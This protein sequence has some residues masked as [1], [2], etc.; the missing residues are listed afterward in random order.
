MF[1][2]AFEAAL[3]ELG[4]AGRRALEQAHLALVAGGLPCGAALVDA[5]GAAVAVGRNCAYDSAADVAVL[6]GTP[7][8]HAELNVLAAVPT[9]R[10]LTADTLWSTQ[11]PCAMCTAAIDFCGV[12]TTRYLAADPAFLG[13]D[14]P[15]A[16]IVA[17]PTIADPTLGPWAAV[18]NAMFLH[19]SLRSGGPAGER[20]RRNRAVEPE[21]TDLA[22]DLYAEGVFTRDGVPF[23]DLA[24]DLWP[25][26]VE[27]AARRHDRLAAMR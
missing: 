11:Q 24:A 26:L 19:P 15:R 18:G 17:D 2:A 21:C 8:A 22:V 7:L 14:D 16:G 13:S 6:R 20:V 12:G 4:P 1:D 23:V 9:D 10:D 27:A 5:A 25:R 3:E